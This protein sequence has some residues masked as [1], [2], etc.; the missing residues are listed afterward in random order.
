[1][2]KEMKKIKDGKSMTVKKCEKMERL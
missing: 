2:K 1:M